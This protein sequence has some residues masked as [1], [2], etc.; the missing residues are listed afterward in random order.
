MKCHEMF[1]WGFVN[2]LELMNLDI[3]HMMQWLKWYLHCF[4]TYGFSLQAQMCY[5]SS[6]KRIGELAR[7]YLGEI[8]PS[9]VNLHETN[10][11]E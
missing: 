1:L 2:D 11:T 10:F 3:R 8:E 6:G 5:C 4:H 7:V 9:T